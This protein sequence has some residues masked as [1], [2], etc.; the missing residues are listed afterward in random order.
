M[1]G[2]SELALGQREM[3]EL[4][5]RENSHLIWTGKC[6]KWEEKTPVNI[7]GK[8][9]QRHSVCFRFQ[10]STDHACLLGLEIHATRSVQVVILCPF[11]YSD[12]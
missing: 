6:V 8:S 4:T 10:I 1:E 7:K 11:S 3:A 9:F 5:S 2:V 12:T